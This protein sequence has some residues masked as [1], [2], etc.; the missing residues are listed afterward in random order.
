MYSES[1]DLS[2]RYLT[3]LQWIVSHFGVDDP[4]TSK[5]LG[6]MAIMVGG[7]LG[8]VFGI[9]LTVCLGFVV[10]CMACREGAPMLEQIGWSLLTVFAGVIAL[11][12]VVLITGALLAVVICVIGL[13]W[14]WLLGAILVIGVS[15][16]MYSRLTRR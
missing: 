4:Y 12:I 16:V 14:Q 13:Y 2:D 3:A 5:D 10:Y 8:L 15:L 6:D 1:V 11:P 7:G 9:I